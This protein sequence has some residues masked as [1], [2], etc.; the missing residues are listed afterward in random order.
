M[1]SQII[2]RSY[3]LTGMQLFMLQEREKIR[4]RITKRTQEIAD[5]AAPFK[6][7]NKIIPKV[8]KRPFA[9]K[10]GGPKGAP[11]VPPQDYIDLCESGEDSGS[12]ETEHQAT[13]ADS[14]VS[15]APAM[16]AAAAAAAAAERSSAYIFR[17]M[18]YPPRGHHL[19]PV[20]P[21]T[22]KSLWSRRVPLAILGSMA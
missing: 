9:P 11:N 16:A 4:Q 18:Q 12:G 13:P 2:A 19:N 21:T 5:Q 20:V 3:R 7:K 6:R 14:H 8:V 10:V 1:C 17:P 15:P 22:V